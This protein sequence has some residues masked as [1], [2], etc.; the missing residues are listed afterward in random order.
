MI[1][2]E[3]GDEPLLEPILSSKLEEQIHTK[4]QNLD[5][6]FQKTDILIQCGGKINNTC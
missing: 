4:R 6:F 5:S 1:W 3:P 2:H